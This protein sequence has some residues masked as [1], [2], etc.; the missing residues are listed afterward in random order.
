MKLLCDQ[1]LGSLATWLRILGYDTYF[2]H[3]EIRDSELITIAQTEQRILISRDKELIQRAKKHQIPRI[4]ILSTNLDE[5]L[6]AI[7]KYLVIDTALILTRCTICNTLLRPIEK[8]KVKQLVPEKIFEKHNMFWYCQTC[9]KAYWMGSHY[10]K[11]LQKIN[12]F[13]HKND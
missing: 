13:Q 12:S 9:K 4:E 8:T 6:C 1:M 3:Q 5:Q 7:F 10:T 11:I 2:A